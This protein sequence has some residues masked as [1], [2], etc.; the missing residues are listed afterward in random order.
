MDANVALLE[1]Y[2]RI[3]PAEYDSMTPAQM[4]S[5]CNTEKDAIKRILRSND[6]NMRQ[7][8]KDRVDFLYSI[9]DKVV[10]R[11]EVVYDD[12]WSSKPCIYTCI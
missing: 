11:T 10:R 6:L 3:A 7:L 9:N 5:R 4:D 8:V 2:S 1:C 12:E